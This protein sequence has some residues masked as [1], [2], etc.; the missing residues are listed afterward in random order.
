MIFLYYRI[1]GNEAVTNELVT[2]K[3]KTY[4]EARSSF[5]TDPNCLYCEIR[6]TVVIH[7]WTSNL[8]I[9]SF[10]YRF[11]SQNSRKPTSKPRPL[12]RSSLCCVTSVAPLGWS[13]VVHC[14]R[15]VSWW[16]WPSWLL[17]WNL[18][19]ANAPRRRGRTAAAVRQLRRRDGKDRF[20]SN[21]KAS[22]KQQPDCLSGRSELSVN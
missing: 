22:F 2:L 1:N 13:S 18:C 4:L 17:E 5:F 15:S 6:I 21:L 12:T 7:T 8:P 9:I 16:T 20:E 14:W 10:A 11:S 3:K 19:T